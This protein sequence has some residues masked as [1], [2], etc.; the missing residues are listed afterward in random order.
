[1]KI[2]YDP[3]RDWM[4]IY[5]GSEDQESAQT[6]AIMPGMISNFDID[7]KLISIEISDASKFLDDK[8]EFEVSNISKSIFYF[9][10]STMGDLLQK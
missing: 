7:E 6:V 4:H 10:Q 8:V 5:F 1:M 3:L 9:F 2:Q